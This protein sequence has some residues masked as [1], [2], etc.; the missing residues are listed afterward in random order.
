MV[1]WLP[2]QSCYL[3]IELA[4]DQKPAESQE[5]ARDTMNRLKLLFLPSIIV[6]VLAVLLIR[7]GEVDAWASWRIV[8][9]PTPG[10]YNYLFGVA[11]VSANDV[12]AVG[13]WDTQEEIVSTLIEH[14]DGTT[15][16]VI[17]SPNAASYTYLNGVAVIS[18]NDIWAVG[19]Y[20][21]FRKD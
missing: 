10:F 8:P 5:I 16:Q 21:T 14:W 4:L 9:S 1:Y 6:F 17:Q 19:I 18:A 15:W 11:A 20:D 2:G 3:I 12:W 7:A 13:R